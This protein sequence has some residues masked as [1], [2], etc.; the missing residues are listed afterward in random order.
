MWLSKRNY[1]NRPAGDAV[2]LPQKYTKN[3]EED[4]TILQP[5]K[6]NQNTPK[7]ERKQL[8]WWFIVYLTTPAPQPWIKDYNDYNELKTK[9]TF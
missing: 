6:Y 7:E 2:M 3:R 4:Q 9:A 1:L 8:G 5:Y